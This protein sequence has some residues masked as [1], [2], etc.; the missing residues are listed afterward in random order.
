MVATLSHTPPPVVENFYQNS[1]KQLSMVQ[2]KQVGLL[3]GVAVADAAAR[4]LNGY[5]SEEV[6]AYLKNALEEAH[7]TG[8]V[9]TA[10]AVAE[11]S[12]LAFA[13]VPPRAMQQR[14]NTE[15]DSGGRSPAASSSSRISSS[16]SL[17]VHSFTYQLY[18][19]MLRAMSSARGEFAVEYVQERLVRAAAAVNEPK[20][21]TAEHASLLHTLC[22]LLATPAIYPYAS[23]AALRGYLEPFVAFLTAFSKPLQTDNAD[24]VTSDQADWVPPAEAAAAAER[25]AVRDYTFSVLG[26]VLRQLQSNPDATRNAAFM[27]VPGT[28]AVF[29]EDVQPFVPPPV[30]ASAETRARLSSV[31]RNLET[32]PASISS[33][34]MVSSRW[35]PQRCTAADAA[36]VREGLRIAQVPLTFSQGVA[37]A[38]RL[39]GPTCQRAML[40]GALLGAKLGARCIPLEWLSATADHKAVS[41]MS[42]EVAQWSWNPPHH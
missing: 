12:A 28:A 29:P 42:L 11:S 10:V 13:R 9:R 30:T 18:F 24:G 5:S 26:V 15:H 32:R 7:A 41:T 35:L 19:E 20:T 40:V 31:Q 22:T 25:A 1:F 21:F 39:G 37:Q 27:A 23:D 4:P 6:E 17:P 14:G 33:S 3:V 8:S 38:I 16:A 34:A 2:Q 36:T